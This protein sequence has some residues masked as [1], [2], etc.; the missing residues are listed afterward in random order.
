MKRESRVTTGLEALLEDP[1]P[2][3]GR[4]IGL[5]T[6]PYTLVLTLKQARQCMRNLEAALEPHGTSLD[7]IVW[8]NWSLR[9]LSDFDAFSEEWVRWFPAVAPV[10]Q[11]TLMPSLQ[12]RAG[13]HISIGV[14][15]EA[16]HAT[17]PTA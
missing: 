5:V 3:A 10:G 13:F 17:P 14:I 8:A 16:S 15:A 11:C 7:R 9:D 6:N 12:R 1:T 4:R 2:I